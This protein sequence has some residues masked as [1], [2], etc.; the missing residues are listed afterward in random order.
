MALGTEGFQIFLRDL[1]R[2]FFAPSPEIDSD[3]MLYWDGEAV[4]TLSKYKFPW[5]INISIILGG[6]GG[7]AAGIGS[8]IDALSKAHLL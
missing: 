3:R 1:R 4:Q 5:W 6:L 2:I 8:L 7:A